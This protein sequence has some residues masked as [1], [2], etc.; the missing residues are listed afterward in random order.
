[1]FVLAHITRSSQDQ[2]PNVII[3][4]HFLSDRQ[5]FKRLDQ[6]LRIFFSNIYKILFGDFSGQVAEPL[7]IHAIDVVL[8]YICPIILFNN[9]TYL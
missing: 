3:L 5:A 1:M 8:R 4:H 7:R 9:L 6:F 2:K